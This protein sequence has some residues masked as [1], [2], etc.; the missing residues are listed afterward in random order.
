MQTGLIQNAHN[1]LV[2]DAAYD[3]YGLRLATSGLDQR[4][5]VWQ[6]DEQNG[7][8]TAT[9]DWKAHDAPVS[10]LSWAHPEFGAIIASASFDRTVKIWE[11]TLAEPEQQQVNGAPSTT[12]S[13]SRWVERA[14]ISDAKGSV[15]A[16]E[17]APRHFGLKLATISS[18][19]YLR[20]YECLEAPSLSTWQL[21]E[22]I[23]INGLAFS[24]ASGSHPHTMAMATPTQTL[25]V[26]DGPNASVV[27]SALQQHQNQPQGRPG[28]GNREADGGWCISWCKDRYW[29]EIIAVG[30]GVNGLI[31]II[32]ISPSRRPIL[33]FTL[34]SSPPTEATGSTGSNSAEP[35]GAQP[36]SVSSVAWAPS[37]GRSYHLVATG[38]RDGHVRIW[39]LKP[40]S[41]D[42]ERMSEED[43]RWT[44]SVVGDFDHHKSAVGRV[45]WNVTGTILSSAGNDGR[46]RL[47]KATT[48]NVWR[49]AGHISVEQAEELQKE[50]GTEMDDVVGAE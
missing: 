19:N 14:V 30:A 40:P 45:E 43:S 12:A 16:V 31:K 50:G 27:A 49:A 32:Q 46:I 23:D 25:S 44:G 48:G 37:C 42:E 1:D 35:D 3:F 21:S 8:W 29:G 18:D 26:L 28:A 15:R 10:K 33:L 41:Y 22:E 4:L 11:E 36:A 6:L 2:T 20:I 9:H 13:S 7:T 24:P 47:W 38:S 5:K 39:R 34:D 17:F